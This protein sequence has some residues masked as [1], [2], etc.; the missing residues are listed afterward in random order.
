MEQSKYPTLFK[1]ALFW[2]RNTEKTKATT[3][4]NEK[5]KKRKKN[6]SISHCSNQREFMEYQRRVN[7]QKIAK[8]KTKLDRAQKRKEKIHQNMLKGKTKGVSKS[9]NTAA[10]EK[11]EMVTLSLLNMKENTLQGLS[12]KRLMIS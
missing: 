9:N 11:I 8:E 3:D 6:K 5:M 1:N 10:E 7:A 4:D 12:L 2:P